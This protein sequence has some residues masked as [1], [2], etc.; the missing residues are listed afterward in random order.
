MVMVYKNTEKFD[1]KS[2]IFLLIILGVILF[3]L[4][5]FM[6]TFTVLKGMFIV[7]LCFSIILTFITLVNQDKFWWAPRGTVAILAGSVIIVIISIFFSD[8]SLE[9]R[10]IIALIFAIFVIVVPSIFFVVSGDFSGKVLSQKK[11]ISIRKKRIVLY[12]DSIRQISFYVAVILGLWLVFEYIL[13][14]Q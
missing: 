4:L 3:V 6:K 12:I 11:E 14:V 10:E 1:N 5:L 7:G 9:R 13:I 8:V 2:L